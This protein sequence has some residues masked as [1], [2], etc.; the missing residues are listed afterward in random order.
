MLLEYYRIISDIKTYK[1]IT[2]KEYIQIFK[3][4]KYN[5]H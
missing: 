5:Y 1:K 3:F 4:I 2:I